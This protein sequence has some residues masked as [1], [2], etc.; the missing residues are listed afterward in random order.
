MTNWKSWMIEA[1]YLATLP[2]RNRAN[3][4]RAQQG[5]AP[6][7]ILFYHRVAD[8]FPN[9][10]SISNQLFERQINWIRARFD[11][12]SL[13]ECQRRLR[14]GSVNR[15]TVA[16]TF[17]DGYSD[18]CTRALPF[19]IRHKLPCTYFVTLDAIVNGTRFS[20]DVKGGFP[21]TPNTIEQIR[22][23]SNS[24]IEIGLHARNHVNIGEISDPRQLEDEI[25]NAKED[26]ESLIDRAVNYFAF[27]YG[28]A[29]NMS[30]SAVQLARD[31]GYH[32]VCSAYGDYNFATGSNDYF[33]LKRI[34]ADPEMSRMKNWL[35]VD[36]RKLAIP[37]PPYFS[38]LVHS[39]T[40]DHALANSQ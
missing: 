15:P 37:E 13:G 33:H 20:H 36:P 19:L 23:L 17:D 6:V 10:W 27:P 32:G 16:I 35:T 11:I 22:D 29:N 28:L 24:S 8:D 1:R 21:S 9:A 2:L 14:S 26:L 7:M 34:H 25:V 38:T 39:D 4:R 30:A 18:N 3:Q 31:V 12:V 5:T 40:P